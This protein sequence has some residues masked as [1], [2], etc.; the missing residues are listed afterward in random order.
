MTDNQNPE[1]V[2]PENIVVSAS[3]TSCEAN[4]S[5]PVPVTSDNC[6]VESI[7]NNYNNTNDASGVYPV[8][9][10]TVVWTVTDVHGNSNE[11]SMT[12][13]VVDDSAPAIFCPE[14]ITVN[15]DPG[16]CE[17]FVSVPQPEIVENCGI[18][19][20]VNSVNGTN[21]ASGIYQAGVTEVT[22]TVTDIN[23]N[24][25]S[26]TME[27]VVIDNE[28][29]VIIC[30]ENIVADAET[31]T[32]EALIT[33]PQPEVAD[34]CGVVS[35]INNYNGT[36][37]A[38]G[39]YPV[40][41]TTVTWIVTD[42]SGNTTECSFTVTVNDTE[43]P[44]IIC[45]VDI[46]VENTPGQCSALVDVPQP[47]T[48]DNCGVESVLNDFNSSSDASGEYPVGTTVVTWTVLDVNGNTSNCSMTVTVSD[49]EVPDITC[50]DD[51]QVNNDTGLCEALVTVNAP[52]TSDNCAV[53][54]V[55][56]SFNNTSDASGI[57]PV[58]VTEVT[59][60][61]TDIHG[62]ENEC[63]MTVTVVD[64]EP[65][66]IECPEDII[67]NVA[68][69]S[70][71]FVNVPQPVVSDNCGVES[72][73]NDYTNTNDASAE[74]PLGTTVVIWTVT[75]IHGR[76]ATCEMSVTI[77]S[78]GAPDI[79]CP[80]DIVMITAPGECD[81][82]VSVETPLVDAPAG[83]QQIINDFNNTDDASGVY[84]VGDTPVIW[85][86]TD[87][88][89]VQ[90]QCQMVV[91][92]IGTPDAID[93]A[94]STLVNVPVEIKSMENDRDCDNNLDP[95]TL[96]V[97]A[98]PASGKVEIDIVNGVFTY[99][100]DTDFIG[101][102]QFD[103]QICDETGYCDI[104]TVFITVTGTI[105]NRP[106]A[107]DDYDTTSVGVSIF[108]PVLVNDYDPDGDPLTVS[109]C[110]EPLNGIV[111]VQDDNTILYQTEEGTSAT[112]DEF[113]YKICDDGN[114]ALCDSAMV[115][116]TILPDTT[117]RDIVIYNTIT[118]DND[119]QNDYWY[120]E[121][122]D[123]YEDN[124]IVIFNRWG[125]EIINFKGYNNSSVRWD[126]KNKDGNDLPDGVYYYII[127]LND[128]N[129]IEPYKGWIYIK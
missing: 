120:I 117:S 69:Q 84:T 31:G 125:D 56:N 15:T 90:V 100:P 93:D 52:V 108:I 35:V 72:L 5:V 98:P 85:T 115:Y 17:A 18:S 33:V 21:D 7:V 91:T 11:C 53:E 70:T 22:W 12:V 75:D 26:C 16:Q 80:E 46:V 128:D 116:I 96:T 104:A 47:E 92:V 27:I 60:I 102:D 89:D 3:A 1:I 82:E 51:I 87:N 28:D 2:C 94:E 83:I 10:T 101:N 41:V 20:V 76:T 88:N 126:G 112:Y 67:E 119:G 48:F 36:D 23:G 107:I 64:I 42:V 68:G 6:A 24:E 118:P 14:N 73:I 58:G 78:E 39:V 95:A 45:P 54:S 66:T 105:N 114:P 110:G 103:Y 122:I 79:T 29:P 34:N 59:W 38:S 121:N 25:N 77:T 106:V 37:D 50:P 8:G 49:T 71:L 62:N 63:T 74:Y 65:P 55:V 30:P 4:V 86:V 19:S 123:Y 97:F 113:C 109:L 81:A 124:E 57:Y 44:E 40:G 99:T 32:C 13:T 111:V 9:V 61:V 129:N 127:D 43:D